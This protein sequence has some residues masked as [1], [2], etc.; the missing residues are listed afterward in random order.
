MFSL[1]L[2]V[3]LFISV[4][5]A[6]SD[7]STFSDKKCSTSIDNISGPNGYP[8]GTCTAF[9]LKNN[10]SFQLVD[11]DPGCAVTLYGPDTTSDP[12]SAEILAVAEIATCYNSSWVY[13]SIDGCD[14]PSQ[15]PSSKAS[16]STPLPTSTTL[17]TVSLLSTTT[18]TTATSSA[19]ASPSSAPQAVNH[20]GVIVGGAVG[21]VAAVALVAIAV[22]LFFRKRKT[23]QPNSSP[24]P[25]YEMPNDRQRFEISYT[26]KP[27]QTEMYA[28]DVALEMGRN[29]VYVPPAELSGD[30]VPAEDRK[31]GVSD[32]YGLAI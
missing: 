15:I 8:N 16:S 6:S 29:S 18:T 21:G 11:L 24:A 5:T 17:S 23:S 7:F 9:N 13:Y 14:I 22:L 4:V 12:C 26:E 30:T 28:H 25:T 1:T 10:T 3:T 19:S 2:P 20:T 32:K 27:V 31:Y